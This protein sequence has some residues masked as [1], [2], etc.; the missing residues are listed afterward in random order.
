MVREALTNQRTGLLVSGWIGEPS[1]G[2]AAAIMPDYIPSMRLVTRDDVQEG[3]TL[4]ADT[5]EQY[6]ASRVRAIGGRLVV[7]LSKVV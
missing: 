4:V 1:V 7:E 2:L 6:R 3:D 5:G